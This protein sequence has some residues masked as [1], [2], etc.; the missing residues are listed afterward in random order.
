MKRGNI[1]ILTTVLVLMIASGAWAL[2]VAGT[3]VRMDYD[4]NLPYAM[5]DLGDGNNSVYASFCL[6]RDNYFYS[7][8]KY[9]VSSAG[10]YVSGDGVGQ[11]SVVDPVSA[12]SKWLYAAYMSKIFVSENGAADMVQNAI[13][14]LEGEISEN[15]TLYYK[16]QNDWV[17]LSAYKNIFD[18]SGWVFAALNLTSLD[19][20]D[21]DKIIDNQGQ[22]VGV[23]PVPEPATLLLLGDWAAWTCRG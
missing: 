4:G 11:Y 8:Q 13:W 17:S 23:A 14:Y 19:P 21:N 18:A 7:S 3:Y 5:T 15:E 10:D 1:L 12:D 16:A 6:E 9:K 20:Y 22:L 2:P